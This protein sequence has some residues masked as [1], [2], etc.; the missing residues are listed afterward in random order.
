MIGR[1]HSEHH[2]GD[3]HGV[4]D[5]DHSDA[6]AHRGGLWVFVLGL[7][8]QHRHD[9]ADSLDDA[10]MVSRAG[11]QALAISLSGLLV[12]AVIQVIVFAVSGSIGL[13]GERIHNFADAFT[14]LPIGLAFVV[15]RRAPT[16]RYTY[17]YGRA[18]DLAGLVVVVVITA[19]AVVAGWEAVNRLLHPHP[20]T[21][22][23]RGG[24]AG[25]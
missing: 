14:A 24:A 9:H 18:E 25:G 10:L 1:E 15:A 13:L 20:V 6:H 3:T 19:S 12:T 16:K 11:I 2:D 17:G 7:L 5:H 22:L 23:R 8:R 4:H 21:N